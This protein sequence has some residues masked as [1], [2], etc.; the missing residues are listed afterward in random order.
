M[1]PKPLLLNN[2]TNALLKNSNENH[3]K[4]KKDANMFSKSKN[5]K[6][7]NKQLPV[8]AQQKPAIPKP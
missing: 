4:E 7:D 6:E 3:K 5:F 1:S 8:M 2:A